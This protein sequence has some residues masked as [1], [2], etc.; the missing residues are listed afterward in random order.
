MTIITFQE[1]LHS[2]GR[3]RTLIALSTLIAGILCFGGQHVQTMSEIN[4]GRTDPK[5][6]IE[7]AKEKTA[8]RE[9]AAVPF[10]EK[11]LNG[12]GFAMKITKT[13]KYLCARELAN[14]EYVRIEADGLSKHDE[15]CQFTMT[16]T[17]EDPWVNLHLLKNN[18]ALAK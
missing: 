13:G 2:I 16:R 12:K 3:M 17:E 7:Q 14:N 9:E 15:A 8:E 1:S 10:I 4:S 18:A 11:Y 5:G 6:R